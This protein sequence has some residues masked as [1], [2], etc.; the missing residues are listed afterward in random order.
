MLIK[1]NCNPLYARV[2]EYVILVGAPRRELANDGTI[3]SGLKP[4]PDS[5]HYCELLAW[6]KHDLVPRSVILGIRGNCFG[7]GRWVS[8]NIEVN[9]A[10]PNSEC[11]F[12]SGFVTD[13]DMPMLGTRL[14]RA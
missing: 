4:M 12:L 14:P 7:L 9:R 13:V 1:H 2:G 5:R 8:V 3:R 11:L 6:R 10:R